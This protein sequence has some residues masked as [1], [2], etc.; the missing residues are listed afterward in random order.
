M[1]YKLYVGGARGSR[2]VCGQAFL[3]FG[4]DTSCYAITD[5]QYALVIDAGSGLS[6]LKDVLA[7]CKKIDVVLSHLHYDHLVG[8]LDFEVFP[9][10]VSPCVYGT[11]AQWG[12][13]EGARSF[14]R[15][16][17]WPVP[18]PR[19]PLH[20][21]ER[22]VRYAF[23]LQAADTLYVTLHEA[24]HPDYCSAIAVEVAGKKLLFL[25][26]YEHGKPIPPAMAQSYDIMFYDAMY[27]PEEYEIRK[28]YGH[29]TMQEGVLLANKLGVK[30]LV[31]THHAPD[32][33]DQDLYA[34]QT[35]LQQE[36]KT[37]LIAHSNMSFEL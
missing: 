36:I 9:K 30:Q 7:P 34:M 5:G 14:V 24:N 19:Q 17:F 31:L 13:G 2:V 21:I 8:F 10:G 37:G 35:V 16:P 27:T 18:M 23:G 12:V 11:F 6:N 33:T 22:G 26:D 25:C 3:R 32:R 20:Q 29:S 4:G 28:G 1:G 15:K